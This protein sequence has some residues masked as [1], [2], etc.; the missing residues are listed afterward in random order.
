M[1][2][3][4]S[5]GDSYSQTHPLLTRTRQ[6]VVYYLNEST[7]WINTLPKNRAE[8]KIK[9]PCEWLQEDTFLSF[10]TREK[11]ESEVRV[12]RSRFSHGRSCHWHLLFLFWRFQVS[13]LVRYISNTDSALTQRSPSWPAVYCWVTLTLLESAKW[14]MS[15]NI[16]LFNLCNTGNSRGRRNTWHARTERCYSEYNLNA[17]VRIWLG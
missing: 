1:A 5:Q 10:Y 8:T 11:S 14:I 9:T 16:M 12:Q 15:T 3:D 17:L 4:I 13:W 2:S 7:F 6:T